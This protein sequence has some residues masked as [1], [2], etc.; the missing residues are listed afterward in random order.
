[1]RK[2]SVSIT[3]GEKT[4]NLNFDKLENATADDVTDQALRN[5]ANA[6]KSLFGGGYITKAIHDTS[7]TTRDIANT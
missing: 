5:F 4:R 1:M 6:V 3:D 2:T 7:Y